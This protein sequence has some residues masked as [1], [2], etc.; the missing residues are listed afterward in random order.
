MSTKEL[1]AVCP[2]CGGELYIDVN[3]D[4]PDDE[5]VDCAYC[6][7]IIRIGDAVDEY[8]KIAEM[9]TLPAGR[10]KPRD[11]RQLM[12]LIKYGDIDIDSFPLEVISGKEEIT[13]GFFRSETRMYFSKSLPGIVWFDRNHSREFEVLDYF[14]NGPGIQNVI[15]QNNNE[16][17][18]T[19]ERS[20]GSL[21]GAVIGTMLLPG[22]GTIIGAAMGSGSSEVSKTKESVV[23]YVQSQEVP[24][25]AY[26]KLRDLEGDQIITIGFSCTSDLDV[27]I[28]N[29]ITSNFEALEYSDVQYAEDD[30]YYE[31]LPAPEEPTQIP[32]TRSLDP[33]E[34]FSHLREL[35]ALLD[36]GV[37]NEDEFAKLKRKL[38]G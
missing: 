33:K 11:I 27:R 22:I 3:D 13:S 15:I 18:T 7:R 2:F 1:P 21:A 6:N 38:I 10:G 20:G 17:T 4:T 12:S 9:K 31:E 16:E 14:W 29:N 37:I 25:I 30:E 8:R 26:M 24:V 32:E 23:S 19:E 36:E 35:K 34:L 5:T 28:K